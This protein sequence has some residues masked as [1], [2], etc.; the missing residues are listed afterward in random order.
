MILFL[1]PIHLFKRVFLGQIP[2]TPRNVEQIFEVKK[3]VSLF[4]HQTL[5]FSKLILLHKIL[6]V[7]RLAIAN[8]VILNCTNTEFLVANTQKNQQA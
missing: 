6:K 5:D 2:L 8:R 3:L 7:T 4:C 1:A